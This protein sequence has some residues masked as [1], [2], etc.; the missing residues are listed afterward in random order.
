MFIAVLFTIAKLWKQPRC[1]TTEEWIKKMWGGDSKMAARGRKEKA[2]LLKQN[3]GEMLETH[4][5]GKTTK[6]KQNFDPSTLP[7]CAEHLHFTLNRETRRAPRLPPDASA[8][9]AWED[10]DHKVN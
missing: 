1:P 2:C 3:V 10:M 4:L 9:T 8:Q 5:A 6:R 7:A